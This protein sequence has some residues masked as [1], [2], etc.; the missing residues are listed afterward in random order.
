[1]TFSR[2]NGPLI[3]SIP[4][5][6]SLPGACDDH[7]KWDVMSTIHDPTAVDNGRRL[8]LWVDRLRTSRVNSTSWNVH[9]ATC[10]VSCASVHRAIVHR[11]D[12]GQVL[13]RGQVADRRLV[14]PS[15][16]QPRVGDRRGMCD[17]SIR[18]QV[19]YIA[20]LPRSQTNA[21]LTCRTALGFWS[22]SA[23]TW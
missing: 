19:P 16:S 8:M 6:R 5:V 20:L 4:T 9:L 23:G 13:D 10:A 21:R 1:V 18:L 7:Q 22:I 3:P 11:H 12:V 17:S 2:P 15:V 14:S